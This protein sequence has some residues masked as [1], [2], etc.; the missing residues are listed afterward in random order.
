MNG[1]EWKALRT[2]TPSMLLSN[3]ENTIILGFDEAHE[4]HMVVLGVADSF[5]AWPEEL[6]T[7][8][9]PNGFEEFCAWF[10]KNRKA[11]LGMPLI[12]APSERRFI[13]L[14]VDTKRFRA[15]DFGNATLVDPEFRGF[16]C[17][18]AKAQQEE[19][20]T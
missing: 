20:P 4:G 17:S 12:G 7:F 15:G 16:F 8:F 5:G 2:S 11:I 3:I 19:L 18:L 10:D 6:I 13:V 14:T 9:P 1:I